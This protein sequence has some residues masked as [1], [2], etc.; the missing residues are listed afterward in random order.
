[1]GMI[2]PNADIEISGYRWVP[3]FAQGFVRDLR[4]RWAC[5]EAGIA[6]RERLANV[7][8]KP[9]W[10][11]QEQPWA[12]VPILREGA[13]TVFESGATLLYLAEKSE[14]LMPREPA[15]RGEVMSWVFAAFNT[16]EP[17]IFEHDNV[18]LFAS[19]EEWAV[20][21]RP[22]LI[23]FLHQR[24]APLETRLGE[25]EWLTGSFSVADIAMVSAL[26]ALSG[27]SI[28]A[29][30]PA[31]EAYIGRGEAR[32]GF[33]QAM[34]DQMAAFARHPNNQD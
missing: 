1:M 5:E 31:L 32:P 21:R 23:D 27:T 2:D 24:L 8:N 11:R 26:R 9:D 19:E 6:Y 18:T 34:A 28:L 14:A 4:P 3:E 7:A 29:A 15:A 30:H 12:Q 20:L 16:I 17:P 33:V 13:V 25:Q 22:S 10:L